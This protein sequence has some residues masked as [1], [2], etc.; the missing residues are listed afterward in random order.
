[1]RVDEVWGHK[2]RSKTD[3]LVGRDGDHL[4]APYECDI[5]IFRKLRHEEPD[6]NRESDRLLLACIRRANLDVM[7]SR[8]TS[9]VKEN[10]RRVR[11]TI[12]LTDCLGIADPFVHSHH[13]PGTDHAGYSIAIA[14]L[15]KSRK[16]GKHSEKYQQ[17]DTVRHLKSAYGNFIRAAPL[18]AG[19]T[20]SLGRS[21]GIYERLNEDICGSLWFEKFMQGMRNRMG[22][23]W[24]PNKAM[25]FELFSNF[26]D[27]VERRI[28][29]RDEQDELII[30]D[31]WFT[32]YI[33]IMI[34]TLLSL[35]GSE[36][37]LLSLDGL[38]KHINKGNGKYSV[39]SLFGK[40]KGESG[41]HNHL[42]PCCTVTKSGI[43]V[44]ESLRAFLNHK[45]SLG[46]VFG[47]A[48]C[49]EHGKLLRAYQLDEMLHEVLVEVLVKDRSLFPADVS[50]E[51]DVK[52]NYQCFRT[53]RRTSD[54]YA[55]EM[56]VK[57]A[58]VNIV[59][60]WQ[61]VE[62]AQGKRPG[63]PMNQHYLQFETL[64]QPF[65]RYTSIF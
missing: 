9:T 53:F 15:M 51:E 62:R 50:T 36:G 46:L 22:Q 60:R 44:Q 56:N 25:S 13:M 12:S 20:T 19:I 55:T 6:L 42:I 64:L 32:F 59:N 48:I 1:M 63:R 21:D 47:P 5:C 61:T 8:A 52:K 39:I 27:G 14:I 37:L 30:Q 40:V 57:E 7:W 4:M 18:N 16:T 35:R 3:F 17:Y 49:D 23:V 10:A 54:T 33:Y 31:S 43:K 11:E 24:K 45:K 2:A 58:D 41:E 28:I 65:L 38:W 26:F 29:I 34:S